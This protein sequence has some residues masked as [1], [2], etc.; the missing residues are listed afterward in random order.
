MPPLCK[1]DAKDCMGSTAGFIHVCCSN[2]PVNIEEC[3]EMVW[4]LYNWN[5][6]D[7]QSCTFKLPHKSQQLFGRLLN[8]TNNIKLNTQH[9]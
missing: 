1:H 7:V 5:V 2:C 6:V 4:M 3:H 8:A 9:S